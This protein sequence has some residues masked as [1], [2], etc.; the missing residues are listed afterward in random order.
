M[1]KEYFKKLR[2]TAFQLSI[3]KHKVAELMNDDSAYSYIA[4]DDEVDEK[5]CKL[6][7]ALSL[8]IKKIEEAAEILYRVEWK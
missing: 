1:N 4:E 8:S 7:Q 3:F 2:K 5:N 6:A